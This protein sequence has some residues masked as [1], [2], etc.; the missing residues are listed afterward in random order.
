MSVTVEAERSSAQRTRTAPW[1]AA[2]AGI[3]A[4]ALSLAFSSLLVGMFSAAPSLVVSVGDWVI[5]SVPSGIEQWAI[6][7]LG[8]FDKPALIAGILVLSAVFGG[9]LGIAAARQFWVGVVGFSVFGALGA[10]AAASQ[11]PVLAAVLTAAASVAV[12][13][14][15]LWWLLRA[16]RPPAVPDS[17]GDAKADEVKPQPIGP[18][19]T[20]RSF[21][22]AAG[23]TAGVAVVSTVAGRYLLD[24]RTIA[25]ARDELALPP[26][27]LPAS[28]PGSAVSFDVA[29]LHPWVTPNDEFYRIDTA[30]RVP[31]VNPSTWQ[32]A[33]T[34]MVDRPFEMT[35]DD[36]LSMPLEEHYITLACVS[37]EVG[38]ELVDNARWLGTRLDALLER[39]GVQEGA[40]QI[41]GL[42]V[43]GFSAGFP[44]EVA[45]D[46]RDA[47]VAVGMNG[48]P[49]PRDHGFPARLVVPGLFGY[50]SATKWLSEIRLTTLEGFDSYWIPRGW[51]KF[52][53]IVT[54]SQIDVPRRGA[55]VAAGRTAVAGV[56]YAP[57]RGI[58]RVEVQ[59]DDGPWREAELA[60]AYND[61]TWRQW[62][63]RWDAQPGR[64]TLT[65][66]ATDGNDEPQIAEVSPVAP[67][68]ATGLHSIEVTVS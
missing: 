1:R 67:D 33:V 5:D 6:A 16:A 35:Y 66:R 32:M 58:A 56:A 50:V 43:D 36:L 47:L 12:G 42:S 28:E 53:P 59:V 49:L 29:N 44:T 7:T 34:G 24:Q 11:E 54:Q 22:Q 62:L 46:G 51:A 17:T 31:Q 55:T 13:V 41:V 26:A 4:A 9:V 60:A 8:T 25:A 45:F 61:D 64:H 20:R 48:E 52:G 27:S 40:S 15:T 21:L 14:A 10:W 18:R 3:L 63:Y 37:N 38:G 68:G 2:V 30:L 57:T 19:G 39:A 23:A 65:V